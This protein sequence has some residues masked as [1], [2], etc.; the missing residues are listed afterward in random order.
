MNVLIACEESHAVCIE[1]RKKGHRAFSCDLQECS[2]GHPE[3]HIQGDVLPFLDGHCY[4]TTVDGSSHFI[5]GCWDMIIAF[6]P[7]T[8]LAIS[9]ARYFSKKRTDGRQLQAVWFFC[10]FLRADCDRIAIENPVNIISGVYVS[11]NF[12]YLSSKYGLPLKPTQSIQPFWFGNHARKKT[13]LWLKGLPK[14][15]PSN[16]VDPGKI[17]GKSFSV[18]ASL[19][20]A[21]NEN[22]KCIRWND[23]RTC[24]LRSKTF[25]GIAKAMADQW[26]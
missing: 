5:E 3:W 16:I 17:V 9:G 26:G 10:Q 13:H 2:G 11:E 19:D 4:F 1:F 25:P 20:S 12:N 15:V 7:C 24:K 6:P 8:H 14:L 21:R 18:G 22:G 23:P